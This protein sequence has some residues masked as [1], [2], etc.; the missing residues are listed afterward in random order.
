M[1]N[2]TL[3]HQYSETKNP[4]ELDLTSDAPVQITIGLAASVLGFFA[5]A[6]PLMPHEY[7]AQLLSIGV[8]SFTVILIAV[9]FINGGSIQNVINA[10]GFKRYFSLS[11]FS[12]LASYLI[13]PYSEQVLYIAA[14]VIILA[15]LVS[16]SLTVISLLREGNMQDWLL[17]VIDIMVTLVCMGMLFTGL[18]IDGA[19]VV[20]AV[21]GLKVVLFGSTVL[22]SRFEPGLNAFY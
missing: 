9:C 16:E 3:H 5:M 4:Q 18:S 12:L 1:T 15:F 14:A 11:V 13:T 20:S 7:F 17:P 21:L 2:S 8:A 19:F 6:Y 10:H 22:L